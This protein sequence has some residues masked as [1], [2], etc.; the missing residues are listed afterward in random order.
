MMQRLVAA[1]AVL[2][3]LSCGAL[4][5]QATA[6][7][8]PHLI[9]QAPHDDKYLVRVSDRFRSRGS[10][11]HAYRLR[12]DRAARPDFPPPRQEMHILLSSESRPARY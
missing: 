3:G 7:Y 10:P 4:A 5:Q 12:I 9:F 11:R 2:I 1:V 6:P 8:D